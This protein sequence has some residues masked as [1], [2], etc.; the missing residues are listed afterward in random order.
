MPEQFVKCPPF[1]VA[2]VGQ[3]LLV[4]L[5]G[6]ASL[7]AKLDFGHC[8]TMGFTSGIAVLICST[9]IRDFFG[10]NVAN[11]TPE[12]LGKMKVFAEQAGTVQWLT[13][14]VAAGSLAIVS[15]WPKKWQPRVPGSIVA[16]IGGTQNAIICVRRLVQVRSG[17]T[18]FNT[19]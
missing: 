7:V 16:L 15:L 11:L 3:N 17:S 13:L 10:L 6:D 18:P 12:F 5:P 2:L 14:T 19:P 1:W 8:L 4:L 9:Q